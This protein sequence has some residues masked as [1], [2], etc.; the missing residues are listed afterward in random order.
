VCACIKAGMGRAHSTASL[1][2]SQFSR[3]QQMSEI[4]IVMPD[5]QYSSSSSL[6][7]SS[8]LALKSRREPNRGGKFKKQKTRKTLILALSQA[9]HCYRQSILSRLFIG[10]ELFLR[11]KNCSHIHQ[12]GQEAAPAGQHPSH[13]EHWSPPCPKSC[14]QK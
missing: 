4:H 1:Q 14:T 8:Y 10:L 11:H 9:L 3:E 5:K 6:T 2:H 13:S 7:N 12:G